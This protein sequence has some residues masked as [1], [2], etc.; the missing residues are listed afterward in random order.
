[1]WIEKGVNDI[2]SIMDNAKNI[3]KHLKTIK[4]TIGVCQFVYDVFTNKDN[5]QS[6]AKPLT[7][8][9]A[10]RKKEEKECNDSWDELIRKFEDLREKN[11]A[12]KNIKT[13]NLCAKKIKEVNARRKVTLDEI[14]KMYENVEK[15]KYLVRNI[16]YYNRDNVWYLAS[17]YE[18]VSLSD[19]NFN[20]IDKSNWDKIFSGYF[21]LQSIDEKK[22]AD[23][24][25]QYTFNTDKI[26]ETIKSASNILKEKNNT[27]RNNQIEALPISKRAIIGSYLEDGE[28][29]NEQVLNSLYEVLKA[30][31]KGVEPRKD[32]ANKARR[33]ASA[34]EVTKHSNDAYVYLDEAINKDYELMYIPVNE[35]D[36]LLEVDFTEEKTD[37]T[38]IVHVFYYNPKRL[39]NDVCDQSLVSEYRVTRP[40]V[41]YNKNGE[42]VDLK[43]PYNSRLIYS[44]VKMLR[45]NYAHSSFN[46][47]RNPKNRYM[48]CTGTT[49]AEMHFPDTWFQN[50]QAV[51]DSVDSVNYG[52]NSINRGS[53][54]YYGAKNENRLLNSNNIFTICIAPK[55]KNRIESVGELYNIFNKSCYFTIEV[56]DDVSNK[57]L[58]DEIKKVRDNIASSYNNIIDKYY[59]DLKQTKE[60]LEKQKIP[61]VEMKNIL[62]EKT[63]QIVESIEHRVGDKLRLGLSNL[64]C[65][66]KLKLKDYIVTPISKL[67]NMDFI[68]TCAS[69]VMENMLDCGFLGNDVFGDSMTVEKQQEWL[70]KIVGE[71]SADRMRL[72]PNEFTDCLDFNQ[73]GCLM[74]MVA[75]SDQFDEC[76]PEK[77][78]KS[79][80]FGI[81]LRYLDKVGVDKNQFLS[82]IGA[83]ATFCAL[84][85]TG[86]YENITSDDAQMYG[87][88]EKDKKNIDDMKMDYFIL[89]YIRN[90][91]GTIQKCKINNFDNK[92]TVLTT[93]R[94]A[95]AH[96][97]VFAD[98]ERAGSSVMMTF[99]DLSLANG[100]NGYEVKVS[101]PI[102]MKFV[103]NP[104]FT[105]PTGETPQTIDKLILHNQKEYGF[106][107]VTEKEKTQPKN[108]KVKL[109][110]EILNAVKNKDDAKKEQSKEISKKKQ[111]GDEKD[112]KC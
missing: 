94:H 10:K 28:F 102:L 55:L 4:S 71:V 93:L 65:G 59:D 104:V 85:A 14:A 92:M 38:G 43:N 100:G 79:T 108:K 70:D 107:V 24:F 98:L 25:I 86:Y 76:M 21:K 60:K 3:D 73:I 90:D 81:D 52:E 22:K 40:P 68:R 75:T 58:V 33:Y 34:L 13:A 63:K 54:D 53:L 57:R 74:D 35:N 16:P 9:G 8:V 88:D 45:N 87:L 62:D 5:I 44:Y 112:V 7:W 17:G 42:V 23:D 12:I 111:K 11:L 51:F 27:R 2:S 105:N 37:G 72:N 99:K 6:T 64:T 101:L 19:R 1:M 91:R 30:K 39:V 84:C 69:R 83:Y 49:G 80:N 103:S 32:D 46:I 31:S 20:L 110:E 77:G 50:L 47:Y 26:N 95:V 15:T 61:Y 36:G 67:D 41:C 48:V 56:N 109:N 18:M 66:N 97:N 78:G 29:M 106:E 82:N 89:N 96:G